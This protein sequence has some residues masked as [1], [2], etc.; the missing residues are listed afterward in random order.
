MVED[1]R[2]KIIVTAGPTQEPIDIIRFITNSSSGVMGYSIARVASE[3][4]HKVV[5][6]S[7]PTNL[8]VPEN[9]ESIQIQ[10]A[11]QMYETVKKEFYESDVII[12]AAA[13]C[14]FKLKNPNT[15][16][17]IKKE[18]SDLNF[19][20]ERTPDILQR[21]KRIKDNQIIVGFALEV[22]DLQNKAIEKLEKKKLDLIVANEITASR[23][24][25]GKKEIDAFIIDKNQRVDAYKNITK[26]ELA[27]K[28]IDKVEKLK[29]QQIKVQKFS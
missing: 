4:N 17:K 19:E 9:V 14:D 26:L 5:L 24:P 7:G 16:S 3:K 25:F 1:N 28:I 27:Q 23:S 11:G 18:D 20:F 10:T 13:V 8:A 6:I 12:M 15:S 2:L 22:S 21:L 29:L